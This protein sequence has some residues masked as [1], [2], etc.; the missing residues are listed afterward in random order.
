MR[1][2]NRVMILLSVAMP[3]QDFCLGDKR[4]HG[5][6]PFGG[7]SHRRRQQIVIFFIVI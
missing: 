2:E 4:W 5:R 1:Q 3:R 6:H 7:F